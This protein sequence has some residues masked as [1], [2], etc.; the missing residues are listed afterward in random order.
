MVRELRNYYYID[1]LLPPCH[2]VE[3]AVSWRTQE[4]VEPPCPE[5]GTAETCSAGRIQVKTYHADKPMIISHATVLGCAQIKLLN[6]I[7]N[8]KAKT[9]CDLISANGTTASK[10]FHKMQIEHCSEPQ[11]LCHSG[12][13]CV[14][15]EQSIVKSFVDNRRALAR[16]DYGLVIGIIA[17]IVVIFGAII[18]ASLCTFPVNK[19]SNLPKT[20][21]DADLIG[22]RAARSAAT[23]PHL[24]SS[25]EDDRYG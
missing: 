11:T 10:L 2:D 13:Y 16:F 1:T 8:A 15:P 20:N 14:S 5:K 7:K 18:G 21:E 17:F 12:D 24:F 6:S 23:V 4:V 3:D 9:Q 25:I 22:I 19:P